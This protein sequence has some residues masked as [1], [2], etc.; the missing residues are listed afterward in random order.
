MRVPASEHGLFLSSNTQAAVIINISFSIAIA[1]TIALA[2][3]SISS[4]PPRWLL[5]GMCHPAWLQGSH[6]QSIAV[7]QSI[8]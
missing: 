5:S 6:S 1:V 2:V 3:A 4:H 8:N 7:S